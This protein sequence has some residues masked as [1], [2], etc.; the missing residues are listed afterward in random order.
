M[1]PQLEKAARILAKA[2]KILAEE[3][4]LVAEH[5]ANLDV[6][7]L[8]AAVEEAVPREAVSGSVAWVEALVPE[9][10]GSAE[11]AMRE[12]LALRYNTVRP[13]VSLLDESNALG[14][15]LGG[16]RILKAVRRLPALSRRRVKEHVTPRASRQEAPT[17]RRAGRGGA[18][19]PS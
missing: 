10:D 12:E 15:A 9:D 13:F 1:L 19:S 18:N 11:A 2:S 3:L 8:W 14:A 17:S 7:A 6:A 16:K 5:D 4:D